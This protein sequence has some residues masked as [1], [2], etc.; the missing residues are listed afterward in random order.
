[1]RPLA[2]FPAAAAR[3][4][5]FVL[6]DIDDTLTD[7]GRLSALAYTAL[8]Q[9]HGAGLKVIP[10]TGRPGGW[11]D[12]IARQW[13]VDA[14]VGEN[15][16]FYFYYDPVQRHMQR[17]YWFDVQ[18]RRRQRGALNAL[19]ERIIRE[20]P[21]AAVAA[22]QHYR[23]SDLA[24]DYREDVAP[25]NRHA[26]D[27]IVQI[28]CQAGATAKVS[29]IHVNGWFGDNDKSTMSKT[30]LR[31]VFD[32]ELG[33]TS[34]DGATLFVGDSPNDCP[35]F[36]SVAHAFGV[37]NIRDFTDRLDPAPQWVANSRGG[38]GFAEI[39]NHLLAARRHVP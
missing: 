22:D 37:A 17:R 33:A 8:E 26:V 21:G 4:V 25:L 24:I 35:M 7:N 16:A 39:A 38:Q 27:R 14:V 34:G 9:L 1:M 5:R 36:A 29:S 30:L 15:G 13:P 20:V 23:E 12:L 6:C 28:F 31:E 11:C 32:H 10:V 2:E 19:A 18:T 3:R